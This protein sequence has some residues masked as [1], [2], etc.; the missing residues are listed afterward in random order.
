M[1][2]SFFPAH[3]ASHLHTSIKPVAS[4]KELSKDVKENRPET[5][6]FKMTPSVDRLTDFKASY[7]GTYNSEG[8][9]AMIS[10]KMIV[11]VQPSAFIRDKLVPSHLVANY[12]A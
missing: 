10:N 5:L 1:V 7:T 3:T 2:H 8:K 11:Y 4:T 6:E 9:L 12:T